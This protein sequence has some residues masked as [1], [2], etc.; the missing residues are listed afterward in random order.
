MIDSE[1][2]GQ[3]YNKFKGIMRRLP[4]TITINSECRFIALNC[5]ITVGNLGVT[6]GKVLSIQDGEITLHT[7]EYYKEFGLKIGARFILYGQ[8]FKITGFDRYSCPGMMLMTCEKDTVNSS[9]DD[10]IND[11]AG[12]LACPVDITDTDSIK[13]VGSTYN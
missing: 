13:F 7:T 11:I 6:D 4:H 1:V 2:N 10:L 3:R 9:T 8:V 12:G 5:Y